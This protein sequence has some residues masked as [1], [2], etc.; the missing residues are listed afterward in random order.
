MPPENTLSAYLTDG[1]S[2]IN[3]WLNMPAVE[4]TLAIGAIQR[5]LAISGP[6]CEIGVWQGRYLTLLSFL[7][8]TPQPIVGIDPFVH[9]QN[10]EA[11]IAQLWENLRRYARRPDVVTIVERDSSTLTPEEILAATGGRCQFV[12]VDGD[13][14]MPGCLH[15]MRLA[16]AILAPR[17]VVALDDICNMTCPGVVEAAVRYGTAPGSP[18]APFLIAGNKLFMT[19]AEHCASFR[20]AVLDRCRAGAMGTASKPIAD[21]AA[22]MEAL[23]VPVHFLEQPVLVHP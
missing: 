9:V 3:G 13:H 21:F 15:D 19:Q 6:V 20:Q 10:R 23:Q 4:T 22:R 5:E 12:S 11:Q 7:A 18:L 17:G 16:E 14:T 2:K 8:D 1:Y